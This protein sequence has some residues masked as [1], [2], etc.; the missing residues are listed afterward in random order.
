[1]WEV[2]DA[3]GLGAPGRTHMSTTAYSVGG[4]GDA[5]AP[6]EGAGRSTAGNTAEGRW[7]HPDEAALYPQLQV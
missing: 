3:T 1:M 6:A 7:S 4:S 5:Q 2:G